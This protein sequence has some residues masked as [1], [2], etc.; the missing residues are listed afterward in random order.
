M[1]RAETR[2]VIFQ[3]TTFQA[4]QHGITQIVDAI[5]PT[6]GPLPR[7]VAIDDPQSGKMPKMLDNGGTIARRIFQ[8]HDRHQN[9]G[10]MLIREAL[11]RLYDQ[12]GDGTA[13]AAVLFGSIFNGG[14]R[15]L[16]T[17]AS[18]PRL[19]IYLDEGIHLILDT[20]S[21][22]T[23]QVQ[24]KETLAQ[25]AETICYDKP[26]A[27]ML[28][29]IFDTLGEYG[30]IEIR[31]GHS[32]GLEREYVEGMYWERGLVSRKMA[33]D[34][35]EM[36]TEFENAAIL[37]SDL[38][39]KEPNQIYPVL[40][41]ALK[42]KI[43]RCLIVAGSMSDAVDGFLL[44]NKKPEQFQVIAVKTPGW[45]AQE[46]AWALED[47]AILTGGRPFIKAAGETFKGIT[48]D[49]FG[50]ARRIWAD[51]D[52]FGIVGGKGNPRVLRQHIATMRSACEQTDSLVLHQSL[53]KR[54]GK[55]LGGSA[56]LWVGGATEIEI[57]TGLERTK[58]TAAA[59]RG[60]IREGVVSGGGVALLA[61]KP[62]LEKRR[63]QSKELE[64]QAAYNI[65][66]EAVESPLRTIVANAGYD[67]GEILARIH[68]A[69]NGYGF[70][71]ATGQIIEMDRAGIFD[72]ASVVKA[73]VYAG[74]S[75]AALALSVDVMVHNIDPSDHP[76]IRTPGKK[77]Q[78]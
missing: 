53:L 22:N 45:G 77:K 46:Q 5:R 67:P 50:Y 16:A 70:D 72:P 52:N 54:I 48:L 78:L 29:E 58:R 49:D 71:V 69:G 44:T 24:G 25:V 59:M 9:V 32:L 61:C 23:A 34:Q 26:L 28:G 51:L 1:A 21:E 57:E 40:E 12:V 64:A 37:I 75:G 76:A 65:L 62:I 66:I 41:V 42:N 20:L 31:G 63:N 35:K 38:E 19:K 7:L 11:L 6:L 68:L 10:A 8:I 30:R 39:I 15:Y 18:A 74:M 56:T 43:S 2:A 14:V 17:G 3:P 55:L 4:M 60:A 13:T 47:L 33:T 27:Q 73:A 36:R